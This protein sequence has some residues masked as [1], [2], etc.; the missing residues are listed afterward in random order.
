[1]YV[2]SAAAECVHPRPDPPIAIITIVTVARLPR[3]AAACVALGAHDLDRQTSRTGRPMSARGGSSDRSWEQDPFYQSLTRERRRAR[4]ASR[5]DFINARVRRRRATD[6]DFRDRERARRYGL[7]LEEFRAILGRQGN[8]CAI[9]K[10]SGVRLYIDHCHDTRMVRR[11]LCGKC[12]TGL[13]FFGDDPVRL[14]AAADYLEEA[15]R[16]HEAAR[17]AART[18]RAK[19]E[20][21][22]PEEGQRH[23][24][25]DTTR[26]S[27]DA[28]PPPTAPPRLD[29][30]LQG[31]EN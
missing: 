20:E 11:L 4:R 30:R 9:C 27:Q 7:S 17:A 28:T 13:G 29:D 6:A 23:P 10:R 1:L 24:A 5:K 26:E 2:A 21:C 18:D 14:R 16:E 8:A 19:S 31:R 15:R 3:A 12:N 22:G 25:R